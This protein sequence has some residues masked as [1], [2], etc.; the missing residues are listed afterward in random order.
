MQIRI[1]LFT[2]CILNMALYKEYTVLVNVIIVH[3]EIYNID[4]RCV[5]YFLIIS[6]QAL[7]NI[8]KTSS[9]PSS[10]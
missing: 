3:Q 8:S 10:S 9:K 1:I 5:E 6:S 2:I 7:S 4:Y